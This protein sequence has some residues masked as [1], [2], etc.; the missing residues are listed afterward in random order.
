[1]SCG[2]FTCINTHYSGKD[3]FAAYRE[4]AGKTKARWPT[5]RTS[6]RENRAS[7]GRAVRYLARQ[8]GIRQFLDIGAGLPSA[9]NVH[10]VA[11]STAPSCRVV[12]I[13]NDPWRRTRDS[14][15]LRRSCGGY[16]RS[17]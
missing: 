9:D 6:A 1:M 5:I 14:W 16:P 11:Q 12:Y 13:D 2:P 8:A 15:R 7:L 4:M 3:N 17:A 10:E